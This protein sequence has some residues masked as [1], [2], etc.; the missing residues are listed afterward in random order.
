MPHRCRDRETALPSLRCRRAIL[1]AK[2]GFAVIRDRSRRV[3]AA[4]QHA[5]V[6]RRARIEIRRRCLPDQAL[7]RPKAPALRRGGERP[8]GR[9]VV[10]LLRHDLGKL[11]AG[12]E[13]EVPAADLLSVPAGRDDVTICVRLMSTMSTG[14]NSRAPA[15]A[16]RISSR[17]AISRGLMVRL[18]NP[19]S[20]APRRMPKRSRSAARSRNC[21]SSPAAWRNSA[22]RRSA[23]GPRRLPAR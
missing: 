9:D 4:A 23:R 6:R 14:A 19:S 20:A 5:P 2:S 1:R 17:A 10:A 16:A 13:H 8:G 11:V 15:S 7:F 22:S 12:C 18:S 21:V 3:L